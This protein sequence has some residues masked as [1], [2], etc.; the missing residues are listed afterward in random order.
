MALRTGDQFVPCGMNDVRRRQH[1]HGGQ[2]KCLRRAQWPCMTSPV[3]RQCSPCPVVDWHLFR[4][5]PVNPTERNAPAHFT[6]ILPVV[7]RTGAEVMN[8]PV[9]FHLLIRRTDPAQLF[10]E[11]QIFR[12][13][14]RRTD[15]R[16]GGMKNPP[17]CVVR[18]IPAR[19]RDEL[20]PASDATL[21]RKIL[22]HQDDVVIRGSDLAVIE[23]PCREPYP[24]LRR[25]NGR[26]HSRLPEDVA[27]QEFG[28]ALIEQA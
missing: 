28:I 4:I 27:Q 20:M 15:P 25:G 26:H 22:R 23:T 17:E 16:V 12:R 2:G 21:T 8:M 10:H 1:G 14:L 18:Q 11:R 24:R 19:F 5:G 7:I 13:P 6:V 3:A 9:E